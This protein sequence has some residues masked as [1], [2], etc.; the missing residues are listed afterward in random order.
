MV[1]VGAADREAGDAVGGDPAELDVA[2]LGR[3]AQ[4]FEGLRGGAPLL[5]MRC[6]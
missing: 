5:G 2:A 4:D 3:V 1:G 6:R